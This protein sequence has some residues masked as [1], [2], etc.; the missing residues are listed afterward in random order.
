MKSRIL[1]SVV[2]VPLL[3]Y[4][5]LFA[6][7]WVT[8][9]ALAILSGIA[10]GELLECV[11]LLKDSRFL[12]RITV[13]AAVWTPLCAAFLPQWRGLS[14]LA[15]YLLAFA[16]AVYRAGEI[17]FAQL[18][19]ALFGGLLIP[20]SFSSFLLVEA[21]GHRGY[22]LLPFIFSFGSDTCAFFAG[23][24]FGKHKLAPK[25]SPHKTVEGA[26]GGLLGDLV[27]AIG[28]VYVMNRCFGQSLHYGGMAVIGLVCSV[29]AQ[30]GDLT[31][32]LIKRE[33]G[34]KDYGHI[35]LAHGGV[36]DRFDSVLFV[37]PAMALIL[38]HLM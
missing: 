38:P 25:V 37:A 6:P 36:L 24:A 28:F 19:A 32:S 22:L 31:F 8:A 20:Y 26:V 15:Y 2:G 14:L 3:L 10:A 9:A 17:K 33:F 12:S 1:V 13:Y 30:L 23:N 34:I 21:A 35:F 5:V 7:E 29:I 16:V 11:G 18:M 4:V 27:L